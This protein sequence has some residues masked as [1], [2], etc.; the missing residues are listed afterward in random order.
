MPVNFAPATVSPWGV[1]STSIG[2]SG[3]PAG[4][5]QGYLGQGLSGDPGIQKMMEALMARRRQM[6][7]PAAIPTPGGGLPSQDINVMGKGMGIPQQLQDL[8]QPAPQS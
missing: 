2:P 1:A 7:T 6:A 5:Q 3:L 4:M 8:P